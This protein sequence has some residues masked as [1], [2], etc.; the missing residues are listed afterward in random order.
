MSCSAL[1]S[2]S[3]EGDLC[4]I[5]TVCAVT[6]T[7][8]GRSNLA[9]D[10]TPGA[11][12]IDSTRRTWI[13]RFWN[14]LLDL[15]LG[16]AREYPLVIGGSPATIK[17]APFMAHLTL[18]FTNSS[19]S[20]SKWRAAATSSSL[21]TASIIGDRWILTAAHSVTPPKSSRLQKVTVSVGSADRTVGTRITADSY[22]AHPDYNAGNP[23]TGSD[24]APIRLPSALAF[25]PTIQPI[26][27]PTSDNVGT[28]TSACE[29]TFYGW[30]L[31]H[32]T[33]TTSPVNL[34]KVNV[35]VTTS[36]STD[37]LGV[38]GKII[39][40]SGSTPSTG[41]CNGDSGG[42]LVVRHGGIAFVS[43]VNSYHQPEGCAVK[44][45]GHTKT[46]A[47]A[48]WVQSTIASWS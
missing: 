33:D 45:N 10:G 20:S 44:P 29:Q 9:R 8:C 25:G 6:T 40:V 39:C 41:T 48:S 24:I 12:D 31:L 30:G 37:C 22:K 27:Y 35:K 47:F 46:S 38:D 32:A 23:Y 16:S 7:T 17:E 13:Y 11:G 3:N 42:P 5:C 4:E 36:A 1:E 21:C 2:R 28:A 34:Q 15:T 19:S 18:E 26:C 14:G 43:G